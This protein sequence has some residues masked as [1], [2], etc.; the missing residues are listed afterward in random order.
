MTTNFRPGTKKC[1]VW[2]MPTR[3][4]IGVRDSPL[5]HDVREGPPILL[6]APVGTRRC[7]S[8]ARLHEAI[9]ECWELC[10]RQLSSLSSTVLIHISPNPQNMQKNRS[11]QHLWP[12]L[13]QGQWLKGCPGI[14][15]RIQRIMKE[16]VGNA[17][18]GQA[19][20]FAAEEKVGR[21]DFRGGCNQRLHGE[22]FKSSRMEH[23][24]SS[25]GSTMRCSGNRTAERLT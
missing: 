13:F 21:F 5:Q 14:C 17:H 3:T 22:P 25:R 19:V 16:W 1:L 20:C 12:N 9:D 24:W 7:G 15:E 6:L 11:E 8:P 23:W 18:G 4:A 10:G 2:Q